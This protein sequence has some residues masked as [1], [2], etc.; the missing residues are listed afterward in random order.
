MS[1]S[2]IRKHLNLFEGRHIMETANEDKMDAFF[3]KNPNYD[4]ATLNKLVK[5]VGY[6][7]VLDFL[8]QHQSCVSL[9]LNDS[10]VELLFEQMYET[11]KYRNGVSQEKFEEM[12]E[13]CDND[14]EALNKI[15]KLVGYKSVLD[16]LN[17][18]PA[19]LNV[20]FEASGTVKNLIIQIGEDSKFWKTDLSESDQM[21]PA[22][23]EAMLKRDGMRL[24]E[25]SDPTLRE[26]LV[27][28]RQTPLAQWYVPVDMRYQFI[29][30]V[31]DYNS[32]IGKMLYKE[33]SKNKMPA[34]ALG[35]YDTLSESDQMTPADREAMLK[36]D[37]MR[38]REIT[39]PTI[40]ECLVAVLQNKKAAWYVPLDLRQPLI[41]TLLLRHRN[42]FLNGYLDNDCLKKDLPP[43]A[44]YTSQQEFKG[45]VYWISTTPRSGWFGRAGVELPGSPDSENLPNTPSKIS[46]SDQKLTRLIRHVYQQN[47]G[48][49][50]RMLR[51]A[52][53]DFDS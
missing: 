50:A 46:E 19:L 13:H 22:D 18:H 21:T 25:I 11:T 35:N 24:R 7:S 43:G 32:K 3:N 1:A 16:M 29:N 26:C 20:T 6:S 41:H 37:G 28:F 45:R 48:R 5:Y 4:N 27:A 17:K 40:R 39:D 38:L 31:K 34:G 15:V 14:E 53:G 23:R 33:T 36:R 47:P 49:L 52:I 2:E 42:L 12:I 30:A 44:I 51:E 10:A 8:N 9:V